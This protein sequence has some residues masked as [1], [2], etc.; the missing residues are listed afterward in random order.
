MK[1]M[2][3]KTERGLRGATAKD[4]EAWAKFRR[5][6]ETMK[7]GT[8]LR[9]ES[10]SPRNG[11]HHRKLMALLQLIAENSEVYT[12]VERA[13]VAVKLIVGHFEPCIDPETGEVIKVPKSI[14]FDSMDQDEFDSFYSDAIDGVLQHVLPKFDR[15]TAERLMEM[16]VEGWA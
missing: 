15:A 5:R 1:A 10:T 6:L 14:A 11:P 7:P 16:I 2:L 3:L 8:W 13:L 4:Q 9:F 12:T